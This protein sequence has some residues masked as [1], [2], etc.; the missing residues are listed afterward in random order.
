MKRFH[1]ILAF[2]AITVIANLIAI[3]ISSFRALAQSPKASDVTIVIQRQ[4]Q[5][6]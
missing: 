1:P 4:G 3:S 5:F 2:V 6:G